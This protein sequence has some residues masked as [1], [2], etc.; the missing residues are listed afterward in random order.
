MDSYKILPNILHE[1]IGDETIL[2]DMVLGDYHSLLACAVD[3]WRLIEQGASANQIVDCLCDEYQV[4]KETITGDVLAFLTE[5]EAANV[6][7]RIST[8]PA[9]DVSLQGVTNHGH[10]CAPKL[11]TY[12]DMQDLLT[13]D[14]I[15]DVDEMGWP[16]PKRQP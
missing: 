9:H 13:I 5:L 3:V 10:Y 11:E 6:I 16:Q 1:T 4:G 14:P 7:E 12:T 15:H 8:P 2:L